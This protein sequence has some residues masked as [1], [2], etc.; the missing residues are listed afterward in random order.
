MKFKCFFFLLFFPLFVNA[1]QGIGI[2]VTYKKEERIKR[3]DIVW[4][5][6]NSFS[7]KYITYQAHC[8]PIQFSYFNNFHSK[9]AIFEVILQYHQFKDVNITTDRSKEFTQTDGQKTTLLTFYYRYRVLQLLKNKLKLYPSLSVQL[10]QN[11]QFKHRSFEEET[12]NHIGR[13]ISLRTQ[14]SMMYAVNKRFIVDLRW[15]PG[16][17]FVAGTLRF[18]VFSTPSKFFKIPIYDTTLSNKLDFAFLNYKNIWQPN[19]EFGVKYV[20]KK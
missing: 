3:L 7:R 14:V 20:F 19:F 18:G 16:L 11:R 1:Q 13:F 9:R 15:N 17:A 6:S 2:G 12:Q 4:I 10:S 8:F 5:D